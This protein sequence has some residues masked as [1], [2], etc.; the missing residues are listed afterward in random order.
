MRSLVVNPEEV[1][2]VAEEIIEPSMLQQS[3]VLEYVVITKT[4]YL[5]AFRPLV[6]WKTKKG[7]PAVLRDVDWV[8][9]AYS[10]RDTQEKIRNYLKD[11]EADSGL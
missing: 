10:G 5:D 8:T 1:A 7:I 9:S 4:T 2:F 6:E 11:L 3:G